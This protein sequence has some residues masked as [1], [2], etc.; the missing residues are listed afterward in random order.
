[1]GIDTGGQTQQYL[2]HVTTLFRFRLDGIQFKDA[3]HDEIADTCIHGK[4]NVFVGLVVAVEERALHGEACFQCSIHLAGR[5]Q[6]DGHAF[7]RH[8][9]I[10]TLEASCL[11]GIEGI[12]ALPQSLLHSI[13]I[14]MA[15]VTDAVFIHQIY[16]GAVSRG[17][18][19]GILAGK[20]QMTGFIDTNIITNHNYHS[21]FGGIKRGSSTYNDEPLRFRL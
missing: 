8:N 4:G 11:A 10:N 7:F 13:H 6:V 17:K 1:M 9:F 2:L 12:A 15:I 16:R 5:N 14:Q 18:V 21:L 3:I 19:H 20:G